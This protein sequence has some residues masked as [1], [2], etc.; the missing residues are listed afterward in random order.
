MRVALSFAALL[1][2]L[3][4]CACGSAAPFA[5]V[6]GPFSGALTAGGA[7]TGQFQF[8]YGQG[9]IGGTG[10]LTINGDLVPVS[11]SAVLQG[12]SFAGELRNENLGSGQFS[13]T[14][15]SQASAVGTFTFVDTAETVSLDGTWSAQA[16]R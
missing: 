13:G 11:I 4:C 1:G 6:V 8:T 12:R 10:T 14:F 5:P 7:P 3:A 9:T 2:L 15:G 16:E